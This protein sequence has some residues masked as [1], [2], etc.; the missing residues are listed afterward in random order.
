MTNF[1]KRP[2]TGVGHEY[3]DMDISR[4]SD[5]EIRE[6]GK[7]IIK[8]NVVIARNQNLD[9]VNLNR[10]LNVIGTVKYSEQNLF[11]LDSDISSLARVTNRRDEQGKKTGIFADK[12]L[13]WHS[14]GNNRRSGRECCV[15]LYCVAPGI[16]SI[17]SFCDT[18]KAYDELTPELREIVNDVDCT[19]KFMNNTFYHLEE[20][21]HEL[22]MFSNS[23]TYPDGIVKPLVYTHPFSGERGLY[24]TFH[25][26]DKMWRRSGAALDTQWLRTTLFEHVF[27]EK[28]IHHHSWSSGDLIFMDQ[29]HS[30]HKRNEV[31]GDRFLYRATL[32]YSNCVQ[33]II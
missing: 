19:F 24:F 27:Q 33:P 3:F 12:E 26:I 11:F 32:D 23:R 17:T 16:D 15:M 14:N 8:D 5:E 22:A 21:D 18:R 6:F 30:I 28:Y 2:F 31:K 4:M 1:N 29:F 7:N 10:I 20:D 9:K 13:D 25:S